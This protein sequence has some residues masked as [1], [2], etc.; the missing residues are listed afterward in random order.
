[1]AFAQSKGLNLKRL[2]PLDTG[3][4]EGEQAVLTFIRDGH[5]DLG[6]FWCG[7]VA[8]LLRRKYVFTGRIGGKCV[9]YL[10][11]AGFREASSLP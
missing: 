11:P 10:T 8:H 3:L 6:D 2:R 9:V 5:F 1:M 4:S 7:S